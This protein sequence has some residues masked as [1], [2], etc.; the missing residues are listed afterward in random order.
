MDALYI[1]SVG[2]SSLDIIE[3]KR[4]FKEGYLKSKKETEL[5]GGWVNLWTGGGK[6][7]N[8]CERNVWMVPDE[9]AL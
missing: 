7:L 8:C 1:S 4:T 3:L 2:F 5:R 9:E 6:I